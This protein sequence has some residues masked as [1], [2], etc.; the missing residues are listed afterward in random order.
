MTLFVVGSVGAHGTIPEIGWVP[1]LGISRFDSAVK[2]GNMA[3]LPVSV[4]VPYLKS[5]IPL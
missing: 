5:A 3:V 4:A 2:S 1:I